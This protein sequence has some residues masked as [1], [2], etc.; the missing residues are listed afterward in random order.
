MSAQ[1]P[2]INTCDALARQRQD[3]A[4]QLSAAVRRQRDLEQQLQKASGDLARLGLMQIGKKMMIR[5]EQDN[6]RKKLTA[7]K[8]L[9]ESLAARMKALD[10][11][12]EQAM[13]AAEEA[14]A[15]DPVLAEAPAAPVEESVSVVEPVPEAVTAPEVAPAAPLEAPAPKKTTARRP[16]APQKPRAAAPRMSSPRK[17]KEDWSA[18]SLPEQAERL[19]ARLEPYY[20][21]H[22]VFALEVLPMEL[23]ERLSAIAAASG[24]DAP[25]AFLQAKG[26]QLINA[27][28]ARVL[29]Q[30]K[31]CTPGEEPEIIRPRLNGVLRRME[32]HYPDRVIGRSIQH[33]HK[34][35]AQDASALHQWLGYP[36]V[37]A[38]LTAYGF[39]YDVSAGG[40][41][42]TDADGLLAALRAAYAEAEKPQTIAQIMADHPE[43][44]AALKTLQNQAP[45]RFGM[46]LRQYL[47]QEGVL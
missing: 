33:D 43:M 8:Q 14:A 38:M 22:Q 9:Q 13:Q 3:L 1:Q 19:L 44:A 25:G 23:R 29:R 16:A 42:A 45:R 32:K 11:Q 37:G 7:N 28:E 34:S 21:E 30:G 12:L 27:R 39:R 4:D 5:A 41:P 17:P 26:W 6:I 20:P 40:R 10:A 36:S 15:Q 35:L 47:K 18:L 24:F 31:Y 2:E 46:S